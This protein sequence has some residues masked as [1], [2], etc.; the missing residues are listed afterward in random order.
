[1]LGLVVG[2]TFFG[3][4]L[5]LLGRPDISRPP[6][7]EAWPVGFRAPQQKTQKAKVAGFRVTTNLLGGLLPQHLEVQLTLYKL[8]RLA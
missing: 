8:F 6:P 4:S 7:G 2:F 3:F 1:M 5:P